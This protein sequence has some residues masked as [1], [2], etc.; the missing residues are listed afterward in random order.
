MCFLDVVLASFL[1]YS[2]YKGFKNGIFVEFASL[3]SFFVGIY[4]AIRFSRFVASFLEE[5]VSWSPKTIQITA[6]ILVFIGVVFGVYA[7]AKVFSKLASFVFLGWLNKLGGV[8]FAVIK[9]TLILGIVLSLFQKINSK[10][11]LIS[12]ETQEKS[13]LFIPVL[14]T[15]EI[16]FPVL[17]HWFEE[18][19]KE[20]R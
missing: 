7:L 2:A 10:S 17:T 5:Y 6:F 12:K 16:L 14:K 13:L 15:S 11:S 9:T 8:V 3:V 18:L 20:T 19:K 1:V 4:L